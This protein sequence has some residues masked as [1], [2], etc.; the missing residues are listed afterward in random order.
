M[1]ISEFKVAAR[2]HLAKLDSL[3]ER[4][5]VPRM[6][7]LYSGAINEL[8]AKLAA[9]LKN[10]ASQF[11]VQQCQ[12]LLAQARLG[13]S[14]LSAS[15]GAAMN[16]QVA[17][18][19]QAS[20]RMLIESIKRMEKAATGAVIQLPIE[21]AAKFAGVVDR[22]RTSLLQLN[23]RS[24]ARYGA[25][26]VGKI[27]QS[28][29]MS[30]LKGET[31][32]KAIDG[33]SEVVDGEWW[34][35]ERIVRTET[36][37]AYNATHVDAMAS[38]AQSFPDLMMRWVELVSDE[39]LIKLDD[40]VGDD[41]IAMHGQLARP[42]GLFTMP[43]TPPRA[44]LKISESLLN[45]SWSHPPNR[46]ND[47]ATLQPW[48]PGWGWGWV[49]INGSRA[50]APVAAAQPARSRAPE[51]N[52]DVDDDVVTV[53][54]RAPRFA[55]KTIVDD[56]VVNRAPARVLEPVPQAAPAEHKAE[57]PITEVGMRIGTGE[58]I[59]SVAEYEDV[60]DM[61]EVK[62]A[63]REVFVPPAPPI[64]EAAPPPR[65]TTSIWQPGDE[66]RKRKVV[67]EKEGRR[68]EPQ[69]ERRKA[70]KRQA[71]EQARHRLHAEQ[72]ATN[73]GYSPEVVDGQRMWRSSHTG[74]LYSEEQ[75]WAGTLDK[76]G[77]P[78]KAKA[79]QRGGLMSRLVGTFKGLFRR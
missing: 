64:V 33:V 8:E 35:A 57:W 16:Q 12:G 48:R 59:G 52:S 69:D 50:P 27:E 72:R 14:R 74:E 20:A 1:A 3:I 10:G 51:I 23:K 7:K 79:I 43:M 30:L 54:R 45:Q 60:P 41:S 66:N 4:G 9:S 70:E 75:V 25:S 18:T 73:D 71:D 46:P 21:Q 67:F 63:P 28:L 31:G 37:W 40:R 26:V 61:P 68:W 77:A 44:G 24:M 11:S 19:Q 13:F 49:M 5:S 76:P 32:Y 22:R 53:Q 55:P 6:R 65:G 29:A 42:G 62:F 39:S 56:S 17:T 47:R 38:T 78:A 2:T 36:A 15:M 58:R 34:R